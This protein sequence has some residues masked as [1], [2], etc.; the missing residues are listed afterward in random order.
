MLHHLEHLVVLTG[1]MIWMTSWPPT[2]NV[3]LPVHELR[4][5]KER[6]EKTRDSSSNAAPPQAPTCVNWDD[7]MDEF[8]HQNYGLQHMMFVLLYM[9]LEPEKRE[10]ESREVR[11]VMLHH[12]QH[13]HLS[14][15][16]TT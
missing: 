14:T 13:H 3:P 1:M 4:T 8:M 12:L 15:G 7:V 10:R 9:N 11:Q 5:R 2:H 16:M 6:K